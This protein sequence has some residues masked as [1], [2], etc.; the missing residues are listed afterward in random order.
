M[1]I[2]TWSLQS[3]GV[4]PIAPQQADLARIPRKLDRE[5]LLRAVLTL[6]PCDVLFVHRDAEAQKPALRR[7][8]IADSLRWSIVPYVPVVPIRMTEA[9]LLANE[10]AIR[11]AAGN[12]NGTEDLRLP[13]LR[14]LEALPDPKRVLYEALRRASGLNARRRAL[15]PVPQRV[16]RI[17][18]YIDDFSRL[19]ALRAFRLLQHDIRT[20]IQKLS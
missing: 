14:G 13:E 18:Q 10:S 3:Q 16:H 8:E 5:S 2:L 4:T 9:W 19:N 20:V 1:P 11:A 6:Y 15:I 17:P 12:P 7:N